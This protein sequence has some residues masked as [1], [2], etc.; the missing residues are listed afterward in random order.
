MEKSVSDI[1]QK[2]HNI[3]HCICIFHQLTHAYHVSDEIEALLTMN[4][5]NTMSHLAKRS[6]H[7]S[8]LMAANLM[9]KMKNR[10]L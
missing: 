1:G 9:L 7:I 2:Y 10:K 5:V 4:F 3:F 6:V 8:R